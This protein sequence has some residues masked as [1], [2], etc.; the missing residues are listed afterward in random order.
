MKKD[1]FLI[2]SVPN[3]VKLGSRLNIIFGKDIF[4]KKND[5]VNGVFGGNGHI[6]EHMFPEVLSLLSTNSHLLRSYGLSPYGTSTLQRLLNLLPKSFR[7]VIF[8]EATKKS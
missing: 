3:S 4:W 1:G 5:I 7:A 6:R 8:N 2:G